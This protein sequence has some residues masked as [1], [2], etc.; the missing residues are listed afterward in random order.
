MRHLPRDSATARAILGDAAD[1][2]PQVAHL[3]VIGY[4]LAVGNWQRGGGKGDK[5]KKPKPPGVRP[6]N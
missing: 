1:Y 2:T 4:H 6:I 5:P 3:D